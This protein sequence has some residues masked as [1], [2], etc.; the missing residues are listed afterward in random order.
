MSKTKWGTKEW[1]DRKADYAKSQPEAYFAHGVNGY[2]KY[3]HEWICSEIV[4]VTGALESIRIVEIGCGAGHLLDQVR[5][6]Y[7]GSRATGYDFVQS[8]IKDAND[9]F[10]GS[11]FEVASLPE[12]PETES[13][14]DLMLASEVLYYLSPDNREKTMKN[15]YRALRPGGWFAITSATG[16]RYLG[17]DQMVDLLECNGLSAVAKRPFHAKLYKR[18]AEIPEKIALLDGYQEN[19]AIAN[20]EVDSK[21]Y[22]IIVKMLKVPGVKWLLRIAAKMSRRFLRNSAI[23][24]QI[25]KLSKVFG[26]F[27]SNGALIVGQK[28]G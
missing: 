24:S 20:D 12:V 23:P 26:R 21:A 8:V 1:F 14:V 27:T 13:S 22:K 5:A 19:G 17:A 10:S 6:R 4:K 15:V 3:R 16:P 25:E 7:P 11:R 28:R 18:L 9:R 2:Q